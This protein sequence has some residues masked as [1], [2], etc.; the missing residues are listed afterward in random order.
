[1][2]KENLTIYDII[3][4]AKDE[5]ER[6]REIIIMNDDTKAYAE[7]S[8]LLSDIES[9]LERMEELENRIEFALILAVYAGCKNAEIDFEYGCDNSEWREKYITAASQVELEYEDDCVSSEW[10]YNTASDIVDEMFD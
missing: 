10:A 8:M 7:D 3:N 1:M 2:T 9:S 5:L 4:N 6:A